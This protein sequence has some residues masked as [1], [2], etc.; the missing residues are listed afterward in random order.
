MKVFER[1]SGICQLFNRNLLELER[2][3]YMEKYRSGRLA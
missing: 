3:Q 2:F 1:S